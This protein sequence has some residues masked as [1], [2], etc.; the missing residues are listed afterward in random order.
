MGKDW[1]TEDYEKDE[2]DKVDDKIT[3]ASMIYPVVSFNDNIPMLFALFDAE[4]VRNEEKRNR[5]LEQMDLIKNFN[6]SEIKQFISYGD[7]D[8]TV[9]TKEIPRY[10]E[11]AKESGTDVTSLVAK[12]QGHA[13]EKKYYIK[14]YIKW[15][16]TVQD[17]GTK[18]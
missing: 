14:H 5:L 4:D 6:S 16:K 3:V 10:I 2:I 7:L 12:K 8:L 17:K 18:L 11:K 1:F 13:F 15:L 9:G